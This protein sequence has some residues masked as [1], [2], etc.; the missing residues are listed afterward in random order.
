[1]GIDVRRAQAGDGPLLKEVRLA[2]LLDA[3]DAFARDHD[4]EA[5]E[6]DDFWAQTAGTNSSGPDHTTFF[7]FVDG[8]AVGIVGGHR[9]GEA[10]IELVAMWTRPEHR[11]AG[12]G[13]RLVEAVV[14]WADGDRV[15]L[16]VTRGNDRAQRLYERCRFEVIEEIR[17]LPSD[18]CRDEVRM[19]RQG[20]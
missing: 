5:A 14:E 16:W 17:P 10:E 2:A 6:P 8:A 15:R 7:G 13:E 3:P 19:S 9:V 12:I 1:M 11:G 20:H 4:E 18:P